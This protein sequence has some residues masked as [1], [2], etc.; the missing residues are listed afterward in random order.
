M[1]DGESFLSALAARLC[2]DVAGGAGNSLIHVK[3]AEDGYEVGLVPLGQTHPA[4][5]LMGVV[6]PSD[7]LAIGV[8]NRSR[9]HPLDGDRR[10]KLPAS[11]SVV[12]IVHRDGPVFGHMRIGDE[13]HTDPPAYGLV[14]DVLQRTFGL[15]AAPPLHG[16]GV[17]FTAAWLE[18][19]ATATRQVGASL[20]WPEVVAL[21]PA[22]QILDG[23][24]GAKERDLIM[25]GLALER[26]C[27]WDRLRWL[28]VED[29]WQEPHIAP[30][31]AAWLDA[32]SFSRF[33]MADMA[34]LNQTLSD[35]R[36]VAGA[37]IARRCRTV[38]HCLAA[39][40]QRGVA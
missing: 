32:G 40:A 25:A 15:P 12:A 29:S 17:R 31:D 8:A 18:R 3:A 1:P 34:P 20:T 22:A 33:V 14:L 13:V 16:T 26:A 27:D 37:A 19:V 36:R 5:V 2:D 11:A 39:Q 6:A 9:P 28:V 23:D 4:S 35:V 24:V 38:V 10:R 7:W 21:H 30:V